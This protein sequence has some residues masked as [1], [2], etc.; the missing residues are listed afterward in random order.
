MITKLGTVR[1]LVVRPS[2]AVE[3]YRHQ[4][5]DFRQAA[6]ELQVDTLLTGNFLR[7]GDDL[8]ITSQLIDVRTQNILWKG[9]FDLKY[10]KAADGSGQRGAGNRQGAPLEPLAARGGAPEGRKSR[11]T[12]WPTNIICA[13]WTSMRRMTL[14]WRSGCLKRSTELDPGYALTWAHLGRA[15]TAN[16]SFETGRARRS[17]GRRRPPTRRRLSLHPAPIEA[18][19]LHGEPVHRYGPG[20]A[21][22]A[23]AAGGA[24]HQSRTTRRSTGSWVMHTGS[25]GC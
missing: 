16:A 25:A 2:S 11:W 6:A 1:S 17:T 7:D 3:R 24:G 15:L 10:Q 20:G 18:S 8:R 9:A 19:D 23:A 4:S 21:G 5:V 22:G 14:R 12:P 13:A